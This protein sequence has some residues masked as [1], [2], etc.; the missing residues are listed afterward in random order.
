MLAL[1]LNTASAK[2]PSK[3]REKGGSNVKEINRMCCL[4]KQ[5]C[6]CLSQQQ[7]WKAGD[8]REAG[9]NKSNQ[10]TFSHNRSMEMLTVSSSV[11]Q[12][13][14][15]RKT[16]EIKRTQSQWDAGFK[17]EIMCD[18]RKTKYLILERRG[19]REGHVISSLVRERFKGLCG[20]T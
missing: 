2:F 17:L 8:H 12:I 15:I 20:C 3:Q 16:K 13:T 9:E 11:V 1:N 7:R 5:K 19:G 4:T 6:V 18:T 14:V 10:N